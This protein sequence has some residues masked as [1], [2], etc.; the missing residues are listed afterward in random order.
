MMFRYVSLLL[1]V[2][3]GVLA[4]VAVGA[5][6]QPPVIL[7]MGDSLSADFGMAASQGWVSLL[8]QRLREHELDYSIVNAS[9][10]GDTSHGGLSRLPAALQ[11]HRP[12]IVIIELGANDGL[13]GLSLNSLRDNLRRM[14]E[15]SQQSGARV[16]LIGMRLPPN[17][18]PAY[19]QEFQSIY[20]VLAEEYDT[21]LLPFLLQGIA[22]E[23]TLMQDDNLHPS[24]AAQP[25]VLD[26]I[27]PRLKPLLTD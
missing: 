17:Y 14:I 16:M 19:T 21:A 15:L 9:I 23:R 27:W 25:R 26:N 2:C 1:V 18:G 24:A 8:G 20:R 4:T 10:S 3:F 11:T 6:R 22:T 5:E 13:R 7:V 12:Q